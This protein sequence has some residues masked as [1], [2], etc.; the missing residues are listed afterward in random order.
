MEDYTKAKTAMNGTI[1]IQLCANQIWC[2]ISLVAPVAASIKLFWS[3]TGSKV[4][5]E[6]TASWVVLIVVNLLCNQTRCWDG[7]KGRC[8][9]LI[10]TLGGCGF[11]NLRRFP[12]VSR[13]SNSLGAGARGLWWGDCGAQRMWRRPVA[14][15]PCR[16]PKPEAEPRTRSGVP[17]CVGR[18]TG[19]VPAAVGG[20]NLFTNA[21]IAIG[22]PC[23]RSKGPQVT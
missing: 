14:S 11:S 20:T 15:P 1:F 5:N 21:R 16:R 13:A 9:W 23:V 4:E 22:K 6:D 8:L 7:F 18:G 3:F 2:L 19:L 10:A 17:R 12:R